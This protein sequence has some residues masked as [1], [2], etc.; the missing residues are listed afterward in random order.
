MSKVDRFNKDFA[1]RALDVDGG[2]YF[3][4]LASN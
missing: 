3:T 2:Y 1:K 4:P